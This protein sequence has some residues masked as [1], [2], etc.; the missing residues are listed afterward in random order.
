MTNLGWV[1]I[2]SHD[3]DSQ[4]GM[5][6]V[7]SGVRADVQ[8]RLVPN[9]LPTGKK[10]EMRLSVDLTNEVQHV[11]IREVSLESAKEKSAVDHPDPVYI[12]IYNIRAGNRLDFHHQ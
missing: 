10:A 12:I 9:S 6:R 8:G 4:L 5:T 3:S 1:L 2:G 7:V 11:G